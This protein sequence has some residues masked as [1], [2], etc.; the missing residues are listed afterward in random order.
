MSPCSRLPAAQACQIMSF[1]LDTRLPSPVKKMVGIFFKKILLPFSRVVFFSFHLFHS[2][3]HFISIWNPFMIII[4]VFNKHLNLDKN[5]NDL[6]NLQEEKYTFWMSFDTCIFFCSP[7][8]KERYGRRGSN[9]VTND[10][11]SSFLSRK[12]K[13][14]LLSPAFCL[15]TS[16]LSFFFKCKPKCFL[17]TA[18][19]NGLLKKYIISFFELVNYLMINC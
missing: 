15:E 1:Q 4:W 17:S 5:S 7:S 8:D 14:S 12:T 2:L 19:W 10:A 9:T 6:T 11:K 13:G 18:V 3:L 16:H